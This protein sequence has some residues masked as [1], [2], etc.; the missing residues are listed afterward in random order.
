LLSKQKL[1]P[2]A[3]IGAALAPRETLETVDQRQHSESP[4][5]FIRKKSLPAQPFCDALPQG[6]GT[7]STV[8]ASL[9]T[10][11]HRS[12]EFSG[13]GLHSGE[14]CQI[15]VHPAK[16]GVGVVFFRADLAF[17]NG[18]G[19]DAYLVHA[20]AENV[21]CADHGTTV[22]NEHDIPIGTV[23][24][25]MAALAL[26]QIDNALV[27]V[28]G[29]EIPILDGSSVD[30]FNAF[31]EGGLKTH[32]VRRRAFVVS[33]PVTIRDGDRFIHI[34][35][36]ETFSLDI[37]ISFDG[38]LIGRQSISVDIEEPTDQRRLAEARTFCRLHEVESLRRSGLIR[39]GSLKNSLVVDGDRLLNDE[40]LRDP[41]EF[42]LHK[43][44]DLIGDFYLLGAPIRGAITA[45]R[46]GHDINVRAAQALTAQRIEDHAEAARN[47]VSA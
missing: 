9:Q 20:R 36:A 45:E 21:S 29:P 1:A 46:P 27:E 39:G 8:G 38:C 33:K 30:F 43:A 47:A 14:D 17:T 11:L 4:K 12:V 19:K 6:R 41:H 5:K 26:C 31:Q 25:L 13:V 32:D 7:P 37:A 23:E 24:H 2:N 28:R 18:R 22:A 15:I 3:D 35:P 40:S 42:V 34:E 44:L 16:P 10:T